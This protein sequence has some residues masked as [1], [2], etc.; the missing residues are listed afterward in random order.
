MSASSSATRADTCP[1]QRS[2][3]STI[4]GGPGN[5]WM[6]RNSVVLCGLPMRAMRSASDLQTRNA[7]QLMRRTSSNADTS[8]ARGTSASD[9]ALSAFESVRP[10]SEVLRPRSDPLAAGVR[11]EPVLRGGDTNVDERGLRGDRELFRVG[12]RR[13][14]LTCQTATHPARP[15]ATRAAQATQK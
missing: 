7:M 4:S 10:R 13:T 12:C 8:S 3:R 6:R 14:Q 1:S 2:M 11:G 9:L 15:M 5:E